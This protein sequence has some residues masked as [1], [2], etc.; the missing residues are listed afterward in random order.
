MNFLEAS[1]RYVTS[2]SVSWSLCCVLSLQEVKKAIVGFFPDKN[3]NEYTFFS[4]VSIPTSPHTHTCLTHIHTYT[5][6]HTQSHIHTHPRSHTYI[7]TCAH[8]HTR[9]Q[10][11]THSHTRAHTHIHTHTRTCSHPQAAIILRDDCPFYGIYSGTTWEF[12]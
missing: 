3:S 9:S 6:T 2:V 11:H 1:T 4:K 10:E 12:P 7:H 8:I 5:V